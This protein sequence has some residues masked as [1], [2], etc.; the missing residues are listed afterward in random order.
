MS[1][2][3]KALGRLRD[4][5]NRGIESGSGDG[6]GTVKAPLQGRRDAHKTS[7]RRRHYALPEGAQTELPL[8]F[9]LAV[10]VERL[11]EFGLHTAGP[12]FENLGQQF[13]RIKRPILNIAFG[14][15]GTGHENSNVVMV[16]SALPKSGKTFCSFNLAISIA[17]ERD[18][19]AVLV[20]A[21]VLKPNTSR[22]FDIEERI[23][24]IDYLLDPGVSLDEILVGTDLHDIV[25]VPAGQQHEEAT[26]LLASRRMEQFIHELSARFQSRAIVVDTPPLLLTNEAHVLAEHMGQI[27]LVIEAGITSQESVTTALESLNRDKPINAIVNKA[28]G[29]SGRGYGGGYDGTYYGY[30]S[31]PGARGNV[32]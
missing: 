30:Y 21:D 29:S 20:D 12:A 31:V 15:L 24:L 26:E 19:G 27:I 8:Q 32:E 13:R 16:S 22:A 28:R 4:D 14:E 9:S 1:K 6:E 17:R 5:D 10:D 3:Q 2:I 23:G 11:N 18:I 7:F 25:M